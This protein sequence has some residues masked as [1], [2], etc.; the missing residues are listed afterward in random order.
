MAFDD[1]K[2]LDD[3]VRRGLFDRMMKVSGGGGGGG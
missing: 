2:A 1:S 3:R